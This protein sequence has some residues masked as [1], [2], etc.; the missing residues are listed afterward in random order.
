MLNFFK[1]KIV[2]AK[3]VFPSLCRASHITLYYVNAGSPCVDSVVCFSAQPN[4]SGV[5]KGKENK[6]SFGHTSQ[7]RVKKNFDDSPA[8]K[9]EGTSLTTFRKP[10]LNKL[11]H[12]KASKSVE[13]VYFY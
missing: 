9:S 8:M 11:N 12:R 7:R 4:R 6:N 13:T 10:K 2:Q 3:R 1:E 5:V